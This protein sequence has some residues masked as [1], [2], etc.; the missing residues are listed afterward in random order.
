MH[1]LG[2]WTAWDDG[3]GIG[4]ADADGEPIRIAEVIGSD[5]ASLAQLLADQRLIA[6]AP[7]MLTALKAL[8]TYLR[9]TVHHNAV[10]AAAARAAI[11]KAEGSR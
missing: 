4:V 9:E 8:E 7:E 6:A 10:E 1:T 5:R 3:R 2:S 11:R